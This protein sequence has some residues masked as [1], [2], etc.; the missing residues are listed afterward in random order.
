MIS[1][2]HTGFRRECERVLVAGRPLGQLRHQ[3]TDVFLVADKIVV[4]DED[5]TTPANPQQRVQFGE[6][7]LI[8]FCAWDASVNFY[9][10]AELT[11]EWTA[12]RVLHG[13]VAVLREFGQPE[14][15]NRRQSE[16]RALWSLVNS[17]RL[18]MLK[19]F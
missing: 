12:A 7:L 10:V 11:I 14:I 18:A 9:D 5:L 16:R 17:F 3:R 19:V 4:N 13:H 6:N 1:E 15:R 2:I 8:A